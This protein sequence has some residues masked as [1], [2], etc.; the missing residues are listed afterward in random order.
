MAKQGIEH[1]NRIRP[2]GIHTLLIHNIGL[3]G[4]HVGKYTVVSKAF[5]INSF[6]WHIP[7]VKRCLHRGR[8][9]A[10]S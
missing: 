1:E 6:G 3:P 5:L 9:P 4:A 10:P 2:D 7:T 8:S